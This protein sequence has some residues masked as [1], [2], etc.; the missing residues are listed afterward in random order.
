MIIVLIHIF[1]SIQAPLVNFINT[2]LSQY[3][4]TKNNNTSRLRTG[5]EKVLAHRTT[6]PFAYS[7]KEDGKVLDVNNASKLI[8]IE[9]K[10]GKLICLSYGQDYSNNSGQGFYATQ[11]VVLN[12]IKEGD[13]F[14][15]GDVLCYNHDYFTA[16]PHSTQVNWNMGLLANVMILECD[17]TLEDSGAISSKLSGQLSCSP[18]HIRM[19]NLNKSTTI[20]QIADIDTEVVSS[21][22]LI[23]F[24]ESDI[25]E[26]YGDSIEKS[27]TIELLNKL[28]RAT[29]RAKHDGKVVRIELL[30][31]CDISTM[32]ETMQTLVKK[33]NGAKN[34]QS[35]YASSCDNSDSYSPVDA[36]VSTDRIGNTVLDDDTV[37]VK[38]YLQNTI[39][40]NAGDKVCYDSSLKS[41]VSKVFDDKILT[42]DEDVEV[43]V[44]F[45]ALSIS[46]RLI[47]S[48]FIV[49]MTNRVLEDVETHILDIWNN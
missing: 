28:N 35:K 18:V 45:S 11:N 36:I 1:I 49:G 29:P 25:G 34:R 19:I 39:D 10:S 21:D 33:Y 48:P 23:T 30:Y 12:D 32:S 17:T 22:T 26:I 46:N 9:Y 47:M 7:A 20:H 38:F 41:I 6:P 37:I 8:K 5:Y 14:K 4:A 44:M 15:K 42:E 3:V 43:D 24:D 27:S 31:K 16:D 13:K 40:V 2:Q